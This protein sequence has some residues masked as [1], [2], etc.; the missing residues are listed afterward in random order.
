MS[1]EENLDLRSDNEVKKQLSAHSDVAEEDRAMI[2]EVM[3]EC[4]AAVSKFRVLTPQNL[5]PGRRNSKKRKEGT[6]DADDN[7]QS[8]KKAK[9]DPSF[10]FKVWLY[11]RKELPKAK[12][13]KAAAPS[14][15]INFT[16]YLEK[17]P[18]VFPSSGN[19]SEFITATA[20]TLQLRKERLV[21][22]E[23]KY[24]MKTP[25]TAPVHSLTSNLA[26][27]TLIEE[28]TEAKTV[29]KRIVYIFMPA[30]HRPS[31]E[32]EW[33]TLTAADGTK[34]E[35]EKF[36]HS[37]L[38]WPET[39]SDIC[40]QKLHIE[41]LEN[42][43][44]LD[45]YPKEF[46][47]KRMYKSP[48]GHFYE[49]AS[50]LA[51]TAPGVT[52]RAHPNTAWFDAKHRLCPQPQTLDSETPTITAPV[53]VPAPAAA[54]ASVPVPTAANPY[55][56]VLATSMMNQQQMMQQQM[57]QMMQMN[58]RGGHL[59]RLPSLDH[60]SLPGSQAPSPTKPLT[61]N[62]DDFCAH[63]D[64]NN[65]DRDRLRKLRYKRAIKKLE[66]IDWSNTAGFATLAWNE[67]LGKHD[68][69]L[70]D[71]KAGVWSIDK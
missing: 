3:K 47:G 14:S 55:L 52:L 53:P 11:I 10:D 28:V 66:R 18:F 25:Q 60:H 30:P 42:E 35:A 36:D 9:D 17:G 56:E 16:E 7:P 44:P 8:T 1:D 20:D 22:P 27:Q 67:I 70:R 64:I 71:I 69:F 24:R 49:L 13:R 45:N 4:L 6:V 43:Y 34:V 51:Q 37:A 32:E 54:P 63:Y 15:K 33:W 2:R 21:L 26:F 57:M 31:S 23:L 41:E 40:S 46:P 5:T 58:P 48:S 29:A 38:E 39:E 12:T 62:L 59:S 65:E 61:V 19:F 68:Q 50:K